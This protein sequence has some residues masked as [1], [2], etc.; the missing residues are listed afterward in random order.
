MQL[1][2][3]GAILFTSAAA[4][5]GLPPTQSGE[6]VDEYIA[7]V[8]VDEIMANDFRNAIQSANDGNT[9]TLGGCLHSVA[10]YFEPRDAPIKRRA[11]DLTPGT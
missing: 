8:S 5:N 10:T 4:A 7:R 9:Q 3:L 2:P 11:K 1:N 6:S